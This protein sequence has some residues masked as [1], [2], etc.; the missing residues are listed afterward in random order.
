MGGQALI[1]FTHTDVKDG[2]VIELADGKRYTVRY[3]GQPAIPNF[4]CRWVLL[5]SEVLLDL[6]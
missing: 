1:P 4:M 5:L 2:E 6:Q 3:A